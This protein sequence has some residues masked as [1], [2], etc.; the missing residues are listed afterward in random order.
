MLGVQIAAANA[1]VTDKGGGA[2]FYSPPPPTL[3]QAFLLQS[4]MS[5]LDRKGQHPLED[6]N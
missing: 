6:Y 2:H 1:R 5:L 3:S 4:D